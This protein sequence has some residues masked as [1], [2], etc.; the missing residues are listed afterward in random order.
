MGRLTISIPDELE[1]RLDAYAEE[2]GL[3]VSQVAA[4]A[5]ELFLAAPV[6]PPPAG[7]A[8]LEARAYLRDL[9]L[10]TEALRRFLYE[11][12]GWVSGP[13]NPLKERVPK[14]LQ[15]PP[16]ERT[17]DPRAPVRQALEH[18]R[19][20]LWEDWD[21]IGVRD[22][23]SARDEY[24]SYAPPLLRMIQEGHTAAALAEHLRSLEVEQMG[25]A[26]RPVDDLLPVA[27]RL[28]AVRAEL[29]GLEGLG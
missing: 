27:R 26:G 21:P 7:G 24:D 14:P 2:H 5:L 22:V 17:A 19:R 16:W 8:D 11:T 10:H 6:P 29:D 18:V 25:L 13:L 12:A 1:A 23:S 3:P 15:P 9:A 28:E 20:I 4:R